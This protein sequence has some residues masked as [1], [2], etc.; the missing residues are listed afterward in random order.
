LGGTSTWQLLNGIQKWFSFAHQVVHF[1][2]TI[3][4]GFDYAAWTAE[5]TVA[6]TWV[7]I[8]D[9]TLRYKVSNIEKKYNNEVWRISDLADMLYE[10]VI[11]QLV[12]IE[13][14]RKYL[15]HLVKITLTDFAFGLL[16][17]R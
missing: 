8:N 1:N 17:T 3:G 2:D 11:P 5:N 13:A 6:T 4:H 12:F 7:G 9:I 10:M 15:H 14:P 16:P